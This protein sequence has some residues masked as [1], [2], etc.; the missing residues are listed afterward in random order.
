MKISVTCAHNEKLI[1]NDLLG[2]ISY[3]HPNGD[4]CT[5]MNRLDMSVDEILA[6]VIHSHGIENIPDV[7]A[8][9]SC[10]KKA[11]F[12][13]YKMM[14][15]ATKETLPGMIKSYYSIV[16]L[17]SLEANYDL[18]TELVSVFGAPMVQNIIKIIG[19]DC[20]SMLRTTTDTKLPM[21][22]LTPTDVSKA[23]GKSRESELSQKRR[24]KPASVQ[25]AIDFDKISRGKPSLLEEME[26][27]EKHP[28]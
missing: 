24:T 13:V 17:V 16:E 2:V 28:F 22:M 9:V 19:V 20:T 1:K 18:V 21:L 27:L 12:V 10:S 6:G 26:E 7:V 14:S 4:S 11:R 15:D 8:A 5:Y 25:G 3:S 23:E